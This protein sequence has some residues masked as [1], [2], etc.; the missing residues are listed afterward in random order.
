MVAVG[1]VL[2]I[3]LCDDILWTCLLFLLGFIA[4]SVCH[5][6]TFIFKA[7]IYIPLLKEIDKM[8]LLNPA[9]QLKQRNNVVL[10]SKTSPKKREPSPPK[11]PRKRSTILQ[12]EASTK[13]VLDFAEVNCSGEI[14]S[15]LSTY[16]FMYCLIQCMHIV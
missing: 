3:S 13:A 7:N 2:V 8:I 9:S 12:S 15:V 5:L 16:M 14:D 1:C 10:V 6:M 4:T 11:S